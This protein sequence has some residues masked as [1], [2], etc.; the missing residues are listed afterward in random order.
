MENRKSQAEGGGK[1]SPRREKDKRTRNGNKTHRAQTGATNF[2]LITK[3]P[4]SFPPQSAHASKSVMCQS[5]FAHAGGRGG[6][7][8]QRRVRPG[9]VGFKKHDMFSISI[10]DGVYIQPRCQS[11]EQNET[12]EEKRRN[13]MNGMCDAWLV[14]AASLPR[15]KGSRARRICIT[16]TRWPAGAS[17][18]ARPGPRSA[19]H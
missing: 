2:G 6:E 4:G 12:G 7:A 19:T 14:A 18:T 15:L 16:G 1:R 13:G 11:C 17:S 5:S 8:R 9:Q 10:C 3:E